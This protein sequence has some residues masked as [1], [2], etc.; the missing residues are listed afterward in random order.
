MAQ[1]VQFMGQGLW[2]YII[3]KGRERLNLGSQRERVQ[4]PVRTL[5]TT[6]FF[7]KKL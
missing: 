1:V 2:Y 4:I 3:V 7:L 5:T 6:K